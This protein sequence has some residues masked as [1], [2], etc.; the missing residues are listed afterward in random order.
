MPLTALTAPL[1]AP[2]DASPAASGLAFQHFLQRALRGAEPGCPQPAYLLQRGDIGIRPVDRGRAEDV[3]RLLGRMYRRRGY[4][5]SPARASVPGACV[6]RVT[7]EA[8]H[9]HETIGTLTVNL[10]AALGLHA[11]DLYP[12]EVDRYRTQGARLCEFTRLALDVEA[13][14]KQALACLFHVGFV[15]A[16][17]IYRASDLLIEVNPRHAPFYRRILG[18]ELIG[19]EKLCRR[20]RAP[21]VLLHKRLSQCAEEI[22]RSGGLPRQQC[23]SFYALGLTPREEDELAEKIAG[24]TDQRASLVS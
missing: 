5:V 18:F 7:L 8:C 15:F 1:A 4:H 24:G 3:D 6:R 20:V 9:Q 11:E 22:Q 19:G 14:S 12:D 13:C 10:D 17:R 23:K 16:Y 21:A 2:D